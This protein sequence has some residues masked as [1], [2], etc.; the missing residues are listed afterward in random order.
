MVR[1]LYLI[2]P[3][4]GFLPEVA[5]PEKKINFNEKILWTVVT[6]FIYLVCCQIPLY[7]MRSTDASDPFYWIRMA[8][9]SNKGTLMELGI[10]PILT[11]GLVMQFLSGTKIIEVDQSLKEERALYNGAQKLLGL[12]ITICQGTAYV[13][14]GMYGDVKDLGVG[15]GLLIIFQLTAAGI[16]V[17]ILDELLQKGY[18]LGSGITLFIATNICE[19]VIWRAFSPTTMNSGRGTEY[20]GAVVALFYLLMTKPDKGKALKEAFYRSNLPNMTNLFATVLVFLIVI[21]VQG[22]RVELPVKNSRMR[23]QQ[24]TFPIKLFYTSNIPIILQSAL[25]GNLHFLSSMIYKRY[26]GNIFVNFLG[27]WKDGEG[28]S[29]GA[30]VPTGGLAYYISPPHTWAEI[31]DDPV[32]AVFY[33]MFVLSSCALFSRY[34]IEISGEGPKDIAKRLK[35]QGLVFTG[36]RD[37]MAHTVKK[38]NRYIPTAAAFGGLSIGFL[39]IVADFLGAIGSGTG[40]L[41]AVTIICTYYEQFNREQESLS[42]L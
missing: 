40:I 30:N 7:G 16:I 26:S 28:V 29:Q 3:F 5:Q 23:G 19:A 21:Y 32:R 15:N 34:W 41:L 4:L 10:S 9:A 38:L 42:F 31:S 11:A 39:T 13:F 24:G 8:M 14:N 35:D 33:L 27:Q 18:G 36:A 25:V 6:L 2:K 37:S 20:E 17:G 12:I 22:F 1:F